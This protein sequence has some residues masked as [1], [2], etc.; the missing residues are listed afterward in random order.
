M[1]IT[2]QLQ[3]RRR[4]PANTLAAKPHSQTSKTKRTQTAKLKNRPTA[5][6]DL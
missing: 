2:A 5:A 4:P 6:T 3:N 1:K